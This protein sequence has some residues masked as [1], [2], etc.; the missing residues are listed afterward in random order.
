MLLASGFDGGIAVC[1][2]VG[3]HNKIDKGAQTRYRPILRTC[4]Q[5]IMDMDFIS[6]T[7]I[8]SEIG[9]RKTPAREAVAGVG[10]P[11]PIEQYCR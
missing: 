5:E 8:L 6:G 3:E 7:R 4:V 2:I 11:C 1:A 10:L 9:T